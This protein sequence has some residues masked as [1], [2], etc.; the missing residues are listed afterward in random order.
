M[1]FEIGA[2]TLN[3]GRWSGFIVE[4]ADVSAPVSADIE[5]HHNNG[6]FVSNK[7]VIRAIKLKQS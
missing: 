6:S 7:Q 1:C 4:S 5:G 3:H 2:F